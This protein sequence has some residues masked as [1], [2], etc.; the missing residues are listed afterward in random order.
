[1]GRLR[2]EEI[3]GCALHVGRDPLA[4]RE[5]QMEYG[6]VWRPARVRLEVNGHEVVNIA[7]AEQTFGFRTTLDLAYPAPQPNFVPPQLART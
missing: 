5:A 7:P 6:K 1:M 4:G 3:V 2:L